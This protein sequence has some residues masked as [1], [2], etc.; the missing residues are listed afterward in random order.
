M[1]SEPTSMSEVYHR[2]LNGELPLDE[3]VRCLRL[4][5]RVWK[6]APGSL[7]FDTLPD[8]DREKAA[9]LFNEAIQ[10]ILGSF[11]NGEISG[12]SAARELHPLLFPV[13]VFSLNLTMANGPGAEQAM[14]RLTELMHKLAEADDASGPEESRGGPTRS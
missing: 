5:A 11:M 14:A 12:E 3:A 7:A 2:F 4:N 8:A 1:V 13:G 6:S 9:L 10:P